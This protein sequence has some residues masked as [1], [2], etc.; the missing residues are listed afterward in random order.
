MPQASA[1]KIFVV[2]ADLVAHV[3]QVRDVRLKVALEEQV[4]VVQFGKNLIELHLLPSAPSGLA[5]DLARKLK[6]WTGERWVVSISEERGQRTVGDVKREND[7][8]IL[9]DVR[10]HPT[11]KNVM[12]H[13]PQATIKAVRPIE[14]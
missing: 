14:D 9:L 11:V 7:A 6:T 4:E 12:H 3:A 2:F 10:K 13:F 8:K 5:Q 1:T